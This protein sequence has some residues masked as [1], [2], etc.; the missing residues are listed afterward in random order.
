MECGSQ[1]AGRMGENQRTQVFRYQG[2]RMDLTKSTRPL[3]RPRRRSY[4]IV[5]DLLEKTFGE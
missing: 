5:L 1:A 3:A 2:I 4:R